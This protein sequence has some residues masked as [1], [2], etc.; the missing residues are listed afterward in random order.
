MH[1]E[2]RDVLQIATKRRDTLKSEL[3]KMENFLTVANELLQANG[4]AGSDLLLSG[5]EDP[6]LELH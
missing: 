6:P 5:E 3:G 4:K 2:K 1:D